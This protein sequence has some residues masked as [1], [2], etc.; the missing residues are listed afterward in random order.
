MSALSIKQQVSAETSV[1]SIANDHADNSEEEAILT[2]YDNG[3]IRTFNQASLNLLDCSSSQFTGQHMTRILPQL[4][5]IKL[6]QNKRA[7]PYLRFL[8]RIGYSFEVVNMSGKNF[9][10]ELFY[11]DM[12]HLG[13]HYLRVIIKPVSRLT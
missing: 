1:A 10:G 3:M 8:S 5:E 7:N 4:K 11:N 9:V 2:L 13:R 6:I 12:V